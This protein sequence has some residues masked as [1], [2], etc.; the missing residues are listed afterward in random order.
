M[1]SDQ[2]FSLQRWAEDPALVCLLWH[3]PVID[4]LRVHVRGNPCNLL[5]RSLLLP[6]PTQKHSQSC[7]IQCKATHDS[8]RACMRACVSVRMYKQT[9]TR[10]PELRMSSLQSGKVQNGWEPLCNFSSTTAGQDMQPSNSLPLP[11]LREEHQ[12]SGTL[13]TINLH[14]VLLGYLPFNTPL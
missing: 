11:L 14:C 2:V 13:C 5:L 9:D 10:T 7:S 3:C 12:V 4:P 6:F 8:A 1:G